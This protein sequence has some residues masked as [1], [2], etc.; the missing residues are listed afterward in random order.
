MTGR[1][2]DFEEL[3]PL[4]EAS[5]TPDHR[6]A[7]PTSA[8]PRRQRSASGETGYPDAPMTDEATCRSCGAPIPASQTKCRFCLSNHLDGTAPGSPDTTTSE[9]VGIVFTLVESATFYGAV[10]KG[11]AAATLLTANE[12]DV[13]IDEHRL[14]YDLDAEPAPQLADR[15]PALP[16]A[17]KV[18]SA[19][20]KQLLTAIRQRMGWSDA[21]ASARK[22]EDSPCLY[23]ERGTAILAASHLETLLENADDPMWL[24]PAI[25]LREPNE[26]RP[27]ADEASVIPTRKA[28]ECHHCGGDTDHRFDTH[29]SLPDETWSGQPIWG[30]QECGASRYGPA[31]E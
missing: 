17:T 2:Y 22:H 29:E 3:R 4:G 30:C 14:I 19:T 16:D 25:A 5:R 31:P 10:A 18:L 15:W 6:L 1:N 21:S 26:D 9:L 8:D 23:D 24:V 27:R 11:G 13:T 28:L 20:G 7:D 12:T